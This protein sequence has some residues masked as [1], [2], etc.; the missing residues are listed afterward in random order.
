[1]LSPVGVEDDDGEDDDDEDDDEDGNENGDDD[2][3]L[4]TEKF[5]PVLCA[6]HTK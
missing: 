4:S 3:T 5:S 2:V 1:M 6:M